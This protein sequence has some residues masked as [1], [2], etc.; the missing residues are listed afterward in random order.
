MELIPFF[1][2]LIL[3]DEIVNDIK[4]GVKFKSV[5]ICLEIHKHQI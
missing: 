5:H 3:I 1:N 4:N 2:V